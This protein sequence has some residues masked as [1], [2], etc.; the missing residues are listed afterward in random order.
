MNNFILFGENW[1]L[2]CGLLRK[3]FDCELTTFNI[4]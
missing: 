1:C 4:Q 3:F 2:T